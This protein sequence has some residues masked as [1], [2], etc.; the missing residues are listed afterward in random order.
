M[1]P[2]NDVVA[3]S[4]VAGAFVR[5]LLDGSIRRAFR[6]AALTLADALALRQ[7]SPVGI[8]VKGAAGETVEE[9]VSLYGWFVPRKIIASQTNEAGGVVNGEDRTQVLDQMF[10]DD[11]S[12]TGLGQK[13]PLL[14][15]GAD[16]LDASINKDGKIRAQRHIYVRVSFTKPGTCYMTIFGDTLS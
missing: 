15:F 4:A 9:K 7:P 8:V 6:D 1:R 3:A 13:I 2:F 12:L 10:F 5:G 11:Q 14:A 16:A